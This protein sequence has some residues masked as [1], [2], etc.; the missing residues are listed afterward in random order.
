M[1]VRQYTTHLSRLASRHLAN[2]HPSF[3][4]SVTSSKLDLPEPLQERIA[5]VITIR[6]LSTY[7]TALVL[8]SSLMSCQELTLPC[9]HLRWI[10]P[11]LR[12]TA[13]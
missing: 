2:G 4:R 13:W 11:Q 8:N 7:S 5:E 3:V 10:C 9:T 1:P 6:F 12:F